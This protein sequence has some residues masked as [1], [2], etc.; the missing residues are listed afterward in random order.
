MPELSHNRY[1]ATDQ[2][3]KTKRTFQALGT[4]GWSQTVLLRIAETQTVLAKTQPL[5]LAVQKQ[6]WNNGDSRA[7]SLRT[8]DR[9]REC[10]HPGR[11]SQE[12][13]E[14]ANPRAWTLVTG[15]TEGHWRNSIRVAKWM[16]LDTEW[17][18]SWP[19]IY[20]FLCL[21][22]GPRI[23][24]KV[25]SRELGPQVGA[26]RST[27]PAWLESRG[28]EPQRPRDKAAANQETRAPARV[29]ETCWGRP[30]SDL[31]QAFSPVSHGGRDQSQ[32]SWAWASPRKSAIRS[33]WPT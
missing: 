5:Y 21:G 11:L 27:G 24:L 18:V 23:S 30:F 32:H 6:D 3:K 28:Q 7:R 13:K 16:R 14:S 9:A 19:E 4:T 8:M 26:I 22:V 29:S 15:K 12:L 10:S 2:T 17:L 20:C 25:K 1:R 33:T 31:V